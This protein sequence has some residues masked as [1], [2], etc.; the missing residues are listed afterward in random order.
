[1][2]TTSTSNTYKGDK[3]WVLSKNAYLKMLL[4]AAKYPHHPVAG[5]VLGIPSLSSEISQFKDVKQRRAA[6]ATPVEDKDITEGEEGTSRDHKSVEITQYPYILLLDYIPLFH[7][8]ILEPMLEVAM[9]MVE[10]YCQTTEQQVMGLFY[11]NELAGDNELKP[12]PQRIA[13]HIAHHFPYTAILLYNG[14]ITK[15][16]HQ[17]VALDVYEKLDGWIL[18]KNKFLVDE[19]ISWNSL[20]TFVTEN[21]FKIFDFDDHLDDMTKDWLNTKLLF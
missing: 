21:C 3:E 18:T 14:A 10:E 13:S 20:D 4:H 1:M 9:T 12:L 2:A 15:A 8:H 6:K 5:V 7:G 17:N 16:E 19:G 11:A